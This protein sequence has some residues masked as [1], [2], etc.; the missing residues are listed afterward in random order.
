MGSLQKLCNY[1][2]LNIKDRDI[3][4]K[5]QEIK[6]LPFLTKEE[7]EERQLKKLNAILNHAYNKVPYYKNIFDQY[8]IAKNGK[9]RLKNISDINKIPFLT[10]EIIR[11]EG[12]NLYSIDHTQRK[13]YQNASGGSTGEPTLFLQDHDY[14]VSNMANF[15]MIMGWRGSDPYDSVV[16]F[17]GAAQDTYHGKKPMK[18]KIIDY[19]RNR[20]VYNT[21][22]M[23]P[24]D[25][26]IYIDT[27]NRVKPKLI[28]G[29][30]DTLHEIAKFAKENDIHLDR[31]NAVHSAAGNLD[32]MM[33]KDIEEVFQCKVFNHYGSR[34]TGAIASECSAHDGMHL[35]MEH[36]LLEIVNSEGEACAP[37]E[38]GEI[39]LTTLSNYSMPLI[40]YKIG[41]I[42][43]L[44]KYETCE[45]G[46]TYPKLEKIVGRTTEFFK[47]KSGSLVS[48][49]FFKHL[50]GVRY[51]RGNIK[52]YQVIQTE[53]DEITVKL[54]KGG[55]IRNEDLN[56][57]AEKIKTV[58]GEDCKIDFQFV[59][60]I[61]KTKTGKFLFAISKIK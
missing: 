34:E 45:C 26:K 18:E 38:E 12:G 49:I 33:R 37:G 55:E 53:L 9:V 32:D 14:H 54:V 41:D 40:R 58:M 4:K 48:P 17:W 5:Y 31:Q 21:F 44:Q 47:T 56:W 8:Q 23:N 52:C 60:E 50:M 29:Y 51:D 30:A 43:I 16:K 61:P 2:I 1:L 27:L 15:T 20:I 11:R 22:N 6:N 10:K 19:L 24:E 28:I 7:N 57:I 59:D 46:C 42:G 35:I 3:I 39:V 13:S 36:T 25:I